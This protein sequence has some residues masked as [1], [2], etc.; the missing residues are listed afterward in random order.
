MKYTNNGRPIVTNKTDQVRRLGETGVVV[1]VISSILRRF[2]VRR[3]N[4]QV[5]FTLSQVPAAII[6]LAAGLLSCFLGYRLFRGLLALYGFAGAA[7][8]ASL[9]V[10]GLETWVGVAVVIGGGLAGALL[11]LTVYLA[12]EPASQ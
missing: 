1:P 4:A 5:T 2:G 3:H 9:F 6:L 11:L 12:R 7:Y 8:L 10:D